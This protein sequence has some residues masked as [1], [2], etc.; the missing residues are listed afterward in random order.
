MTRPVMRWFWSSLVL[1][2]LAVSGLGC[3]A[4]HAARTEDA[5]RALDE[6]RPREA[7]AL[8]NEELGVDGAEQ[9]PDDTGG[10]S[11][12]LL[13]DRAMVLQQLDEYELSSRDLETADKQTEVLDFSRN[14][15]DDLAK[16]MFS[17]DAGPYKA[18]PYEKLMIN[19]VNMMNYLV[20]GDLSGARVEARRL[21]VMQRYLR[22][23]EEHGASLTGLGSYLAGFTYEKSGRPQEALRHYDGALQYGEYPSLTEPIRRLSQVATYR[24]PRIT[25]RLAG[26]EPSGEAQ[27]GDDS[28]E[29]LVIVAYGRVPAKHAERAPIGLAL[30]WAASH[31][32][33]S[34]HATAS[35]LA[36]QGLVTWINY[37]E[38]GRSR[39]RFA[40]PQV[41]VNGQPQFV[42]GVLAVDLEADKAWDQAKG[43]VTAAAI[44][45]MI[46]R[47]VAGEAVRR[48]SG[49]GAVGIL[50]SLGTQA[51]LTAADT[52]DTR[53]WAT[54]P[55]RIAISRLR[56]PPGTYFVD[57]TVR[58]IAKRQPV[59]VA[60]GSFAVVNLTILT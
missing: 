49:E 2:L 8:L 46:T 53:S 51:T 36:A 45:R 41:A 35:R 34:Q 55:A 3:F 33:P 23:H 11:A 43:A 9:L 15:T 14:G 29:I 20:R 48:A 50:L 42:E 21:E 1:I 25:A 37:P 27:A 56:V 17:D 22:D 12:L 16:Y 44:T 57:M 32:H 6:G 31:M 38:L 54:L 60:A 30:T 13:L 19:T 59:N 52:P 39:G 47:V 4:G 26:Y 7:L 28:G 10:D 5:R 18:P 58:G 24:T 40:I